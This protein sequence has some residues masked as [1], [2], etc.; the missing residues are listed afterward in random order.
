[1]FALCICMIKL[2]Y[3][4]KTHGH[5]WSAKQKKK[6]IMVWIGFMCPYVAFNNNRGLAEYVG[7]FLKSTWW[8]KREW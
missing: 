8:Y 3:G 2:L 4:Q 5:G 7:T 1:M 6:K